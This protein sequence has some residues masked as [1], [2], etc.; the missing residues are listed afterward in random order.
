MF[1]A[2]RRERGQ[3]LVL[4]ALVLTGILL[5]TSL[6]IDVGN[7]WAQ[8][9]ATQN[10][11][12]SAAEA[13]TVVIA[14]YLAG[15]TVPPTSGTCPL[16]PSP[17]DAWDL[18]VCQAIYGSAQ[19]GGITLSSA[20]YTDYQGNPI[21]GG[22]G[23]PSQ[24][25]QGFPTGAQGIR[26]YGS[27]TFGTSFARVAGINSMTV[28]SQATAVT[29]AISS[30]CPAGTTC[31]ALPLTIPFVASQCDGSGKLVVGDQNWPM[32]GSSQATSSNEVSV[33]ICKNQNI[34]IA[35]NSSGSVGWIDYTTVIPS[36]A[37]NQTGQCSGGN[38]A[39]AITSQIQN[40]CFTNLSFPA[41]VKTIPGGVGKSGPAAQTAIDNLHGDVVLIPLFDFACKDQPTGA[42]RSDCDTY[43]TSS[44]NG[45]GTWY[46]ITTFTYFLV[47]HAD[48]SGSAKKSC[49]S[50]NGSDG[51]LY[52][53]FVKSLDTPGQLQL[54]PVTPGTSQPLGVELIR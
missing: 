48:F 38:A 7:D 46:H 23:Y 10:A 31:G 27:R 49:Q 30:Y 39:G 41:W 24:V 52:G 54:G 50:G 9:R 5:A 44:G 17:A 15:S 2:S 33:P 51:C 32:L 12:D 45:N 20:V 25:G 21:A 1:A 3:T 26:A 13:G 35:G 11:T 14:Q 16:S 6:V 47:D 4:F 18:A 28:T 36:T 22:S 29:D 37:A 42:S 34:G 19:A 43:P 8:Q 53:W 40:N